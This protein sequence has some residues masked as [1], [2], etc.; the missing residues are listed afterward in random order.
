MES[1]LNVFFVN[2]LV[3]LDALRLLIMILQHDDVIVSVEQRTAL[4]LHIAEILSILASTTAGRK[5]V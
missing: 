3:H 2:Y 5:F 1:L 4:L